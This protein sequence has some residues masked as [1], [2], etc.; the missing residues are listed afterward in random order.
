MSSQLKQFNK[1]I[2]IVGSSGIIGSYLV[3]N[4][5]KKKNLTLISRT[6]NKKIKNLHNIDLNN[7]KRIEAFVKS[8]K[9]FYGIIFLVAMAHKKGRNK[10]FDSFKK[11]NFCTLKNLIRALEKFNKMPSKFIFSSTISVYGENINEK[12]YDE[13][14]KNTPNSPYAVTKSDAEV[15]LLSK[16][17]KKVWILRFAPVYS[18]IFRLNVYRRIKIFNLFFFKVGS[19]NKKLSLCNIK[20]IAFTI[21]SILENKVPAS[22][23]NLSDSVEYTYSDLLQHFKA[24]TIIFIPKMIFQ[25]VY[26]IGKAFNIIFLKENSI[27]LL[28][29]NIYPS[30][31]L[32]KYVNIKHKLD[33]ND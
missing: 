2:L 28:S 3:D 13:Q 26:S 23:Y 8:Q 32:R 25:I 24:K 22:V 14:I 12:L 7:K 33:I 10:N 11:K 27:K 16:Y 6:K 31:K 17:P 5:T 18:K 15:F 21:E 4:F 19:G 1:R 29:D 9:T 30:I 20:N